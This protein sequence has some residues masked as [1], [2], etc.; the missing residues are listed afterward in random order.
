MSMA[1][2]ASKVQDLVSEDAEME[3]ALEHVLETAGEGSV[4]WGDVSEELTSGQ[5]GRL[6]ETGVLVDSDGEGSPEEVWVALHEEI[7]SAT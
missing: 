2:T 5:W 7:E 6:I 4:G 1:R 3:A